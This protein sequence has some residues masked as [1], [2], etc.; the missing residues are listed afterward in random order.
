MNKKNLVYYCSLVIAVLIAIF[1]IFFSNTFK[2]LSNHIFIF[3]TNRFGWLYL[4]AML[5]FV[6]F[7]LFVAVSKFGK[8]RLGENDSKP[9]YSNISWFAMLFCAG[10]GVGLVFWGISEPLS[11]YL[12]P[13]SSVTPSS[14]DSIDFAFKS[15]FMHWGIHPWAAYAVIGLPMAYFQFRKKKN[16]LISSTMEPLVGKKLTEGWFGKIVDI[17]AVLKKFTILI[18]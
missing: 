18:L 15:V 4:L 8:I 11:H 10:M 13:I 1:A 14:K 6:V 7:S 16:G 17:F 5:F 3:L 2:S 12:N 9:E